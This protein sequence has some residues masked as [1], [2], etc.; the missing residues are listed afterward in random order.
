MPGKGEA[1][2]DC[3][4]GEGGQRGEG[5]VSAWVDGGKILGFL[6]V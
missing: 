2:G 3:L 1:R 4:D 5:L 6:G